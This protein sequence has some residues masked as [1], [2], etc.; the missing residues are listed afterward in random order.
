MAKKE[1]EKVKEKIPKPSNNWLETF[2]CN[3]SVVKRIPKGD[4]CKLSSL[5][6]RS[7]A[8]KYRSNRGD[9]RRK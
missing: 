8:E 2:D 5:K 4:N 3:E 6:K 7:V 1:D 9:I